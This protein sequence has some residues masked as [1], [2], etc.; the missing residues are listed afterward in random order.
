MHG[1]GWDSVRGS[2]DSGAARERTAAHWL[3]A[4]PRVTSS[5]PMAWALRARAPVAAGSL[6]RAT[7]SAPKAGAL[8][9]RAPTCA[10]R[11]TARVV[12]WGEWGCRRSRVLRAA[13]EA[14]CKACFELLPRARVGWHTARTLLP[15]PP[16]RRLERSTGTVA[17]GKRAARERRRRRSKV[18]RR[19]RAGHA[20]PARR[21]RRVRVPRAFKRPAKTLWWVGGWWWCAHQ[22]PNYLRQA[23]PDR[24]KY[25]TTNNLISLNT[26]IAI[27]R[28]SKSQGHRD[29]D[30]PER[31]DAARARH[32]LKVAWLA[33]MVAHVR[34]RTRLLGH[35]LLAFEGGGDA[36]AG[37]VVPLEHRPLPP[38]G[39]LVLVFVPVCRRG[40]QAM[41]LLVRLDLQR[42]RHVATVR[43]NL[44][45]PPVCGARAR[46]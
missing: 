35:E 16:P 15:P 11:V 30:L 8:R 34:G 24:G 27:S 12:S 19:R 3:P 28:P 23:S 5:A 14:R 43:A 22:T 37:G 10:P 33:R 44:V 42:D 32:A 21:G 17:H 9:A 1:C 29:R 41:Q 36:Q 6:P 46:G 31:L 26:S 20:P 4:S 13:Q 40:P 25:G 18:S 7:R 45:P 38:R 2:R 39:R